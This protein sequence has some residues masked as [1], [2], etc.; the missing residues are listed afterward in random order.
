MTKPLRTQHIPRHLHGSGAIRPATRT[1]APTLVAGGG[2]DALEAFAPTKESTAGDT[3]AA[4][5]TTPAPTSPPPARRGGLVRASMLMASGSMVSRLLGFVRNYLFGMITAGSMT[6]AASAFS[7]ANQ[8]P[9]TI[10]ILV[11]G[12]T[13]NAILVP[14]IVKAARQPDRGSDY[15][16]RL[17]TLVVLVAGAITA[18]CIVAVPLLLTVTSGALPPVTYALAV[19]LGYWM[20]PQIMLSALYV[21]CGQLLNAHDSFGPFQWAPVM[22]NL[23]GILGALAFLGLWGAQGDPTTWTIGMIIALAAMNVGGSAAQV[24]F[25]F[26]YVR[27]LRLRLRPRWG[28]RGLGFGK[29]S[30]LGLWT[31]A[32]LLLAQMGI[33][34]TRWSTGNA[35]HA[36]EELG[37]GS[38][39]AQSYPALTSI[40]WAYLVFMI[41][42]G[43]IAVT[44]VTAIFPRISRH[45]ADAD[46]TAALREHARTTRI[47]AVPMFLSTAV[48]IALAGPIMWVIGGGTEPVG[49]RANAWVLVG[50]MVGLVPFAATYLVKRVFYAYEDARA[51]F[52]MQI[53][54]TVVSLLAVAPILWLVDA[55]YAT[56]TAAAVSSIG[57][58]LGWFLGLYMLRR[59]ATSLGAAT[60]G[61]RESMLVFAKLGAA[62]LVTAAVGMIAVHL[63]GE[64]FWISRVL[65]VVLGAAVGAV[66]C[67]VFAGLASVMRVRELTTM[68]DLVL[69]KVRP[70]RKSAAPTS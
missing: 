40:D 58:L 36:V 17:M 69:R 1:V 24:A 26:W 15:V 54:N 56:A 14:A 38:V 47:L 18:I 42:Q 33:W 10:W 52:W 49:A 35:V 28:F 9:N 45:A 16:S 27:K 44:I 30:K 62:A 29:L 50:Y 48:F 34:A 37:V 32:M 4:A 6:A 22:N 12:G 68:V 43:I 13:L 25:L 31:L 19:Q 59:R 60:T 21:M 63:I 7:A 3:R 53:P 66:L 67:A 20:M 23:V 2:A 41:P 55:H 64:A 11:G 5:P 46:H 51:P 57:N 39:E 61:I 70:S 8:L 65:T